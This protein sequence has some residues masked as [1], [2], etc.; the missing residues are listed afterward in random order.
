MT[1]LLVWMDL[2]MTGLEPERERIIELAVVI[3]DGELN[4]IAEGRASLV[5]VAREPYPAEP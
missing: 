3:T 2:E 5:H 1:D 4:L